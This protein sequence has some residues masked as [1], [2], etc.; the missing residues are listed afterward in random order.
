MVNFVYL[1]ISKGYAYI[2]FASGEAANSGLKYNNQ[3][4]GKNKIFVAISAP[5]KKLKDDSKTLFLNNLPFTINEQKIKEAFQ[6]WAEKI[7][8]IR[9]IE[10][11]NKPKGYAYV[12]FYSQ[13][14]M[15]NTLNQ[16]K[17]KMVID[18]RHIDVEQSQH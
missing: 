14:D 13:E 8:E 9:I 7:E 18:G 11:N 12:E 6:D 2:D 5:P 17:K 1:G 15:V 4:V 10:E 3:L 16:F